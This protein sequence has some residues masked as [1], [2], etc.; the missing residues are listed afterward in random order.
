MG[1]ACAPAVPRAPAIGPSE[2]SLPLATRLPRWARQSTFVKDSLG[3]E[4][5]DA[6]DHARGT[7]ARDQQQQDEPRMAAWRPIGKV[8]ESTSAKRGN[9]AY[10]RASDP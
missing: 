8:E 6:V 4:F 10:A 2:S 5:M 3:A 9:R 7:G 1:I